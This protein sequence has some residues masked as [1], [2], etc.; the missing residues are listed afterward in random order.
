MTFNT[1]PN[2]GERNG[3]VAPSGTR[4]LFQQATVPLGWTQDVSSTFQDCAMRL[5][6][7][8]GSGGTTAWSSWN[9]G[10]TFGVNAFTISTAQMP[11][12]NHGVN[13]PTHAHGNFLGDPG[14]GHGVSDGT[15]SHTI[16]GGGGGFVWGSASPNA[17]AQGSGSASARAVS[18]DAA[19]SNIGVNAA[20]SNISLTNVAASTGISTQFNGSGSGIAP[21]Y[22][23]PQVKFADHLIGI[24]T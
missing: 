6:S 8:A 4:M 21:T 12:H 7:G 24:K 16:G 22:T 15:H 13:D 20:A 1:L 9:F 10:G 3:L 14:H 5:N 23:T 17:I 19:V 18:I 2:G 11:S